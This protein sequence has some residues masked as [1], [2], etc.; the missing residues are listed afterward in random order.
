[1]QILEPYILT[2]ARDLHNLKFKIIDDA[3]HSHV[4]NRIHTYAIEARNPR[5]VY[6]LIYTFTCT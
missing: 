6:M 3:T 5:T 1:M 4:R 2:P